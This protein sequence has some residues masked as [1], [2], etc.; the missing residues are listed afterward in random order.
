CQQLDKSP[1]SF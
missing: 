1:Y